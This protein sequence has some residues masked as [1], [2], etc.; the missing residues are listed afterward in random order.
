[1]GGDL[2]FRTETQD[3]ISVVTNLLRETFWNL[4]Q[5]GADEHAI[6]KKL[7]GHPDF[8]GDLSLVGLIDDKIVASLIS[9]K[10]VVEGHETCPI[11]A[12]GPLCVDP[13]IQGKGI[14]TKLINEVISRAREKGYKGL[15][16]QG[17]PCYYERFGLRCS[18]AFG[19]S[20]DGAFPKGQM[21][22]ELVPDG[23]QGV[24]GPL[25][26]S[27][28]FEVSPDDIA[29]AEREFEPKEKFRTKSQVMFDAVVGLMADDPYP[30]EFDPKLVFDRTAV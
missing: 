20:A 6:A 29:E 25:K 4:Y 24:A 17:H 15:V 18:K 1:M 16:L 14:G 30:A 3:D 5:P 7:R 23:L 19:I 11:L 27:G 9:T 22:L 13:S 21:A 8:L 10:A 26:F 28:G 2:V 12:L